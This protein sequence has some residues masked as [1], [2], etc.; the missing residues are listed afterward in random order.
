[1]KM[2]M[3][4]SVSSSLVS[5]VI[6]ILDAISNSKTAKDSIKE[7]K[8]QVEEYSALVEKNSQDLLVSAERLAKAEKAEKEVFEKSLAVEA[9]GF[10]LSELAKKLDAQ[11]AELE[12]EKIALV[13]ESVRVVQN[14]AANI[15]Q[16]QERE[17]LAEK[18]LQDALNKEAAAEAVV[19]E[20]G[21]KLAK[22]KSAMGDN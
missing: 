2:G 4:N 12:K 20:Y 18:M 1:M 11:K 22:L 19:K 10:E 16:I 15:K 21:E 13:S 17:A 3:L 6:L 8:E 5:D 7:I 14:N 9:R